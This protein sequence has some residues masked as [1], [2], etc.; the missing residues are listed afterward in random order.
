MWKRW[1]AEAVEEASV[2]GDA[3]GIREGLGR[4]EGGAGQARVSSSPGQVGPQGWL[5]RGPGYGPARGACTSL[6]LI[7]ASTY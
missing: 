7:S 4:W 6:M 5:A 1:H 3:N 2:Q